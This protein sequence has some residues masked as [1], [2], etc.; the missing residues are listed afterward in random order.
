M[1]FVCDEEPLMLQPEL[2]YGYCPLALGEKLNEGKL[3][4]VRKLGW[5]S[6]S[7]VWLARAST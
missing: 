7:S 1:T 3:E 2:G 6:C 5:G 4:V